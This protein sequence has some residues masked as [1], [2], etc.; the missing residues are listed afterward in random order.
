M[1]EIKSD[2]VE[3]GLNKLLDKVKEVYGGE[4]QTRLQ[5]SNL[6]SDLY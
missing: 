6:I 2:D 5:I 1:V 3:A 4:V